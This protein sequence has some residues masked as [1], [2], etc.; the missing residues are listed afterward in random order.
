MVEIVKDW[1]ISLSK[2]KDEGEE[3]WG[4]RKT[5]KVR[6]NSKFGVITC[7]GEF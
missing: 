6:I 5:Y 1:R 3:E 4:S 2:R 7:L